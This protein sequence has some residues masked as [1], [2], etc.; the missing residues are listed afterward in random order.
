LAKALEEHAARLEAEVLAKAKR[1]E[2]G[3]PD[4]YLAT[5]G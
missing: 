3:G 5:K 1:L 2:E 4:A